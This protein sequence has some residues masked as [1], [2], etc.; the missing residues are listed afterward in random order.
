[1]HKTLTESDLGG[2][3]GTGTW[4]RNPMFP[5]FTYTDGVKYVADT[6]GAYWLIDAIF[7]HQIDPKARAEE[8]QFWELKRRR[9]GEG[10]TLAMTD[11]NSETP[12]VRQVIEFTDFPLESIR[13]Y[14]KDRVLLL[15]S[16]Y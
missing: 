7:S 8:F 3:T 6:G 10:A 4:W 5:R 9:P 16:E 2:F 1:M 13:F 12:I 14:F 15:P 11:G